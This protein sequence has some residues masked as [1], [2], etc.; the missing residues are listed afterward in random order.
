V[1]LSNLA[2]RPGRLPCS[3]RTQDESG[4]K[5][6]PCVLAFDSDLGA[7]DHVGYATRKSCN[8]NRS[9]PRLYTHVAIEK[10]RAVHKATH[11]GNRVQN[12]KD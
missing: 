11:P 6:A 8:E 10:L 1:I 5:D 7:S 4:A 3:L 2:V 9:A 12:K